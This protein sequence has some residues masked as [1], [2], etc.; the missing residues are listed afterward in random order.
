MPEVATKPARPVSDRSP[1]SEPPTFL[2]YDPVLG[3]ASPEA[4]LALSEKKMLELAKHR[5]TK[6]F[7]AAATSAYP[8]PS[9]QAR[10]VWG[11]EQARHLF[12]RAGFGLSVEGLQFLLTLSHED[13][14][15][16]LL[17]D[18]P[19]PNPPGTWVTEPFDRQ[20]YAQ[21]TREQQQAWQ[22]QNRQRL[23]ETIAWWYERMM[24]T[25]FNLREKMT[26][27][28]HGHFTSDYRTVQLA[29]FLYL[30]NAAWRTHAFGN[31]RDFLKAMYKDPAM[32][33]YLDGVRNV[34]S[35][36][37][38]NF[39]R[40]LLELFTMG[41]GNYS[42]EDIKAA[43]RA[44]TGWE[45][46]TITLGSRLNTRRHDRG[47]KTFMGRTG[48]FG[49]DEIIDLVLEQAATAKHICKKLYEFFVSR[50][51]DEAFVDDLANTLRAS[52]YEIKP[53]LR[54][55][56]ENDFFYNEKAV[57]ALIKAP[58]DLAVSNARTLVVDRLHARYL[59][60][61]VAS[62][63][64]E[65]LN[66]PNVAGWPG[67]RDWISPTT[68][69]S[70]NAF[71]ETYIVGGTIENPGGNNGP[72]RF[73]AM[74]FARSFNLNT[75]RELAQAMAAHLLAIPLEPEAFEAVLTVLVGS[76]DPADWSLDYPGAEEQVRGFLVE[77]LRQPEFHLA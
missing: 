37:N 27:F 25:L 11:A 71:S 57:A 26:L 65:L 64:Q 49:G 62:L 23:F 2:P 13:A 1:R 52:N 15:N 39:A 34:A 72:I 70:R 5:D 69:V 53:V 21:W 19:L 45:V 8:L 41:V 74:R 60:S 7:H 29:Q 51:V 22:M 31:F 75:A 58:V 66:P 3:V 76:A 33:I 50:E 40:E 68:F 44:F 12:S 4:R 20:A 48:N 6:L 24:T 36:P 16:A 17:A 56:F 18:A 54:R 14:L 61:A 32:L 42:E 67:Q 10:Q 9:P 55:I 77:L 35:Q 73:D 63:N 30:Q 38:E 47:S 46:D 43:A 28:W 59:I